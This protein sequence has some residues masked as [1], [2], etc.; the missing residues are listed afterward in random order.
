MQ[1]GKTKTI[2]EAILQI[3]ASDPCAHILVCAPSNPAADTVAGRPSR[4]VSSS[5]ISDGTI[6]PCTGRAS[7]HARTLW[8]ESLGGPHR[9]A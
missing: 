7:V 1:T 9:G 3:L 4:P 6:L 2:V 8:A 5:V